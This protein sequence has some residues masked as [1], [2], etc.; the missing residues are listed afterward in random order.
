LETKSF[1]TLTYGL[2]SVIHAATIKPDVALVM[3]VAN[4]YWLPFLRLR[5]VPTVVNVDGMEWER[6]KWGRVAKWVF[7]TGARLTAKFATHLIFDSKEIEKYWET[8]FRRGGT[9]IP[10]G[11][12][13]PTTLTSLPI[14]LEPRGYLL[15]VARLVPENSIPAFLEAAAVL[16]P[17]MHVVLVGSSGYGGELE[18][19]AQETQDANP[20]FH[21]LG[22]VNDDVLLHTLWHHAGAYFHGHTVGGTNPA[23]VQAM[24]CGAPIVAVDTP[25]NREVIGESGRLVPAAAASIVSATREIVSDPKLMESMA[26]RARSRAE[27]FYS[28]LDV[29]SKYERLIRTAA[30]TEVHTRAPE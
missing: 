28:W 24:A 17:E 3:N 1:S 10:Y 11:G 30:G 4:G 26:S 15:A 21:W 14:G 19:A 27:M 20:N 23:L 8:E 2:T 6:A 16:A 25:Y 18:R 22:H 7:K 5:G 29:C 13:P 9:F 12:Q